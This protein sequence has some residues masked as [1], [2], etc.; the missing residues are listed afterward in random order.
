[1]AR[2]LKPVPEEVAQQAL[3]NKT[4]NA[5]HLREAADRG[6]PDVEED[7]LVL[8]ATDVSAPELVPYEYAYVDVYTDGEER[9]FVAINESFHR[10]SKQ[11]T[12]TS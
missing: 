7:E 3:T 10:R 11:K 4:L 8:L 12:L 5:D 2:F 6:T 9:F 1:M